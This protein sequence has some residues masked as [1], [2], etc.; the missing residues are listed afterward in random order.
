M[1][2]KKI[3]NEWT[4][5]NVIGTH[6]GQTVYINPPSWDCDWYWG[7]GYLGNIDCHYHLDTLDNGKNMYDAIKNHFGNSFRIK[8]DS[9]IWLF[10]ELMAT[11]YHLK[12]TAEVFGRGGSQYTT[13]PV[14]EL[15]K[16]AELVDRINN[17]LL[18]TI[19]NH[20]NALLSKYKI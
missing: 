19:F 12:E 5:I 1:E 2:T 15:I 6:D 9:D 18:P 8:N 3:T 10:C 14:S 11:A 20:V 13:N 7:F 17:V 16:D 4:Q